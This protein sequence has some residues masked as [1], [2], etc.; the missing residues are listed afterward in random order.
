[1]FFYGFR[2]NEQFRGHL[3]VAQ[4]LR[5]EVQ[6]LQPAI[7]QG[8]DQGLWGRGPGRGRE[9]ARGAPGV[10]VKGIFSKNREYLPGIFD[11]NVFLD[12]LF[13]RFGQLGSRIHEKAYD[14]A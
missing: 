3:F 5:H 9:G 8:F 7:C 1:V 4:P 6:D 14:P 2:C 11:G 12:Q 13:E 10:G